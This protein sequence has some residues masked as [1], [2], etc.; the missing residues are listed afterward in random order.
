MAPAMFPQAKFD[1]IPPDLDLDDLVDR[2]P[3]FEWV[4]RVSAAS[5]RGL[6]PQD[7]EQLVQYHVVQAGKP[8]IIE[9]WNDRLPAS[10]FSRD[11]IE[12]TCDKKQENVRDIT[13]QTD[14]PMTTGHYLRSMKQL[15]NQWTPTNFRDE[16]R[17]R[18]Y[19]KDID[20]PV[21]WS[22]WLRK[23]I[24]PNLFYL[25]QNIEDRGGGTDGDGQG[26]FA[27][28]RVH[29]AAPA[30]DL[31]SSLPEEM[32]AQN[33]MCYI[34]HEGT[35]TPAHREMCASLGQNI[36][37]EAS[38]DDNGEKPGSSIWFMTE[39]KDRE[40][41]REYFLSMLGHDIEIEKH[42]AQI[43]AWKKATFPV[44]VAEQRVGDFILVPPLAPHQVWNRGTRTMKVAWNRTT[45][46]T[47][48]L[49]LDE[50]LP[51][52]R[53]VC[54]D[55]Q[56]KNKA[57]IYY[58][59]QKYCRELTEAENS[60][61][62]M[63][64]LG[65]GHDLIQN[66]KRMK[67][68]TKDFK[69]LF[70]LF[71]EIMVGEMFGT[72][73][74]DVEF[75]EFD[76]NITCSY[77]RANIFNRFLTCKHC[78]RELQNGD[79]DTYDIC[80]D[81]YAMGR[82]CLCIS[83]LSWCEQ[84]DWRELVD[85]YDTWRSMIIRQD[86]CID[87][88]NSPMPLE[89]ARRRYGKKAIA[90]VCQ[91][92]LRRRPFKDITKVEQSPE[93]ESEREVDDQG[94][95]VKK[96]KGRK[97]KKGDVYRCHV[98]C[99]KD[100]TYR[101]AFCSNPGCGE[102]YCY[103]VL[104]R[105]F[106]LMP[107]DV[108]RTESWKCPKCRNICNCGAC[109]RQ[110]LGEPYTPKNTLLGHDTRPIA[111]DRSVESLVDFKMH[112]LQWL[113]NSGDESRNLHSKRMQKLKQAAEAEKAKD[114][115][116]VDQVA[117]LPDAEVAE[118]GAPL[119]QHSVVNGYGGHSSALPSSY[120]PVEQTPQAHENGQHQQYLP[121]EG[122]ISPQ[123]AADIPASQ[124]LSSYPDPS[125]ASHERM[126]G[127]GYYEQDDS[128]DRI[129]FHP[130]QAPTVETTATVDHEPEPSEYVKKL[131]RASRRRA[132][133]EDDTDPD[134]AGPRSHQRKKAR[135]DKNSQPEQTTEPL[136]NMDPALFNEDSVAPPHESTPTTSL[137]TS[138]IVEASGA[139][140]LAETPREQDA[141]NHQPYSPNRPSLRHARPKVSYVEEP[142]GE[143][144]FN[145]VL[146]PRSQRPPEGITEF[147]MENSNRDPLDVASEAVRAMAASSSGT[148]VPHPALNT[149]RPGRP[150]KSDLGPS[151]S[152][153]PA[154]TPRTRGR[155]GRPPRASRATANATPAKESAAAVDGELEAEVARELDG[156]DD[157]GNLVEAARDTTTPA[158]LP[159]T[160]RR[161]LSKLS[162][163][164]IVSS[165]ITIDLASAKPSPE[166][167]NMSFLSMAERMKLRGKKA[168]IVA[169]KPDG[170]AATQSPITAPTSNPPKK[171]PR[172][173]ISDDEDFDPAAV[174]EPLSPPPQD[175]LSREQQSIP[176]ESARNEPTP[177]PPPSTMSRSAST[178]TVPSAPRESPAAPESVARPPARVAGPTVVRIGDWGSESESDPSDEQENPLPSGGSL[179]KESSSSGSDFDEDIPARVTSALPRGGA[180]RGR[181]SGRGRGQGRGRGRGRGRG[182]TRRGY[183]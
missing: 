147:D 56:Y 41:V 9:H 61:S 174:E 36:M 138:A 91:E 58:T 48:A 86:G 146:V 42:F 50:A 143:E 156:F 110:G 59:L 27:E 116:L 125:M 52:A 60:A 109:R 103:G 181:G 154:S 65:L 171:T 177:P 102:A 71:T 107:P 151:P 43:N 57:I 166:P 54:R 97:K 83:N 92:Q 136:D 162:T 122:Q 87:L 170:P 133:Q 113:K 37:V 183:H 148:P 75:I 98:C 159:T 124:D 141:V 120:I 101:L 149:R 70:A 99:H 47:L 157:E 85:Q 82:S 150:R 69:A 163:E 1:P 4:T 134:F 25:N 2:T 128:P 105:A 152:P 127:M 153:V 112:N 144:E 29:K 76:S 13:G 7:F 16:R 114:S 77:C 73:E 64:L 38:G 12:A 176:A 31:M 80:M 168:K 49:A 117:A 172:S 55:E 66:S 165:E 169:R 123:V 3:N 126:F 104:Y 167:T 119:A 51:K 15:T 8:L 121:M 100:Y 44:Y 30:G 32:R 111:D 95:P 19:L 33:L 39:T 155:R 135:L 84:W 93:P 35:Y 96:K 140:D 118:N 23:I 106:D 175:P 94:R 72:K 67:Q 5:I 22:D 108:M 20:C 158:S 129:L 161:P 6:D 132:R 79:Q 53:L 21:E 46:E 14:I 178:S 10:L 63:G 81:C 28:Q 62:K 24:P 11:W 131:L 142:D 40:V 90:Q 115:E 26:L 180:G 139:T 88:D 68:L 130:F 74:K 160:Q 18:L 164:R 17:Q 137:E 45:V 34:G 89:I 179:N 145:E 182:G 173:G 78:I